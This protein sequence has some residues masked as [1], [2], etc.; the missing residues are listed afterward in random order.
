[1]IVQRPRHVSAGKEEVEKLGFY[2]VC[3]G[4]AHTIPLQSYQE[5]GGGGEAAHSLGTADSLLS[6]GL[7]GFQRTSS[8]GRN[9]STHMEALLL[10]G[11]ALVAGA[12]L[13]LLFFR[14][15]RTVSV[16]PLGGQPALEPLAPRDWLS[17]ELAEYNGKDG[18]PI[19]IAGAWFEAEPFAAQAPE[20]PRPTTAD[21]IIFNMSSH[22]TGPSFYGP[23]GPYGAMAGRL[24][25]LN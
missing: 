22:P 23:G 10:F 1:M 11:A 16:G 7:K 20:R 15:T 4:L 6:R 21:G 12:I 14:E 18:K 5:R 3:V 9:Q 24:A 25:R 19:Y 17:A 13:Y 8:Q 2:L